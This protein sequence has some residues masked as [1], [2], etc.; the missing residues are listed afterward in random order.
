LRSLF[1]LDRTIHEQY[2][3]WLGHALRGDLGTSIYSGR[4]VVTEILAVLPATLQLALAGM[5]LATIVGIP[6]G[7]WAAVRRGSFIDSVI[8][9]V[10][11][12]GISLPVFWSGTLL[13]MLLSIRYK[14]LPPGGYIELQTDP[15]QSI[16][17]LA[18]PAIT[19]G[20]SIAT[21]LMRVTRSSLLEVL[22]QDY[23][24]VARAKGLSERVVIYRH[25]LRNSLITVITVMGVQLGFVLG[26]SAILE[27][28][29]VRPGI[30][31]VL[32]TAVLRRDYPVIQ[33]VAL[34]IGIIFLC[35]NLVVDLLYGLADPRTRISA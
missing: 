25:A 29:F 9:A 3:E 13:I 4:P 33:G 35:V 26:G 18:L 2:L 17:M 24:S 27:V 23:I 10:A 21:V 28:V 16:R 20:V 14:V 6:L 34:F 8:G 30:G 32:L 19:L 1:G 15:A 22:K 31:R 12:L 5:V 11:Y 7:V